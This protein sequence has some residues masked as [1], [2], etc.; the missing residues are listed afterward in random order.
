MTITELHPEE[1]IDKLSRGCL[2]ESEYERLNAHVALCK[3]CRFELAARHDFRVETPARVEPGAAPSLFGMM[4][5]DRQAIQPR[6]RRR[7]PKVSASAAAL[8]VVAVAGLAGAI[9][10]KL[11][12]R[13]LSTPAVA[14]AP[15][16]A[17][18]VSTVATSRPHRLRREPVAP[19]PAASS[20]EPVLLPEVAPE[21]RSAVSTRNKLRPRSAAM[22]TGAHAAAPSH[23]GEALPAVRSS[24]RGASELFAAANRARREGDIA[25]AR[26]LYHALQSQFPDSHEAKLSQVTLATLQLDTQR[27][28][29]ALADFDGYLRQGGQALEAEALV[30]RALA[31]RSLGRRTEEIAAWQEVLR[32]YPGSAYAARAARRLATLGRF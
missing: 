15:A 18:S 11:P 8:L 25:R 16:S 20:A 22:A 10:G 2:S 7:G 4:G 26:D 19:P 28:A 30:G 27:P 14:P 1:L 13:S 24:G 5:P 12:W 9:S 3:V 23:R 31:L 17:G 32:R 29:D 21:A 6:R